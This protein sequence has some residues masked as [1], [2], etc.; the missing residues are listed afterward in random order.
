MSSICT[1]LR[2]SVCSGQTLPV[3]TGVLAGGVAWIAIGLAG[4]FLLRTG[5]SDYAAA[6]PTKAYNFAML[7]SRLALASVCSISS[8]FV[9]VTTAKDNRKAAWWLGALLLLG[10]MPLHLPISYFNV[11]ADYPAW[12][13]A[14]YLL[15]L[16][17]L[18]GFG[19][20]LAQSVL[21]GAT[22]ER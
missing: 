17:P 9:A 4:L 1:P 2:R 20:Y 10:S 7:L 3:V 6:E 13:H 14:V 12:Y 22:K 21:P 16:M 5:W 19:G 18:I 15:S 8:G 11:W